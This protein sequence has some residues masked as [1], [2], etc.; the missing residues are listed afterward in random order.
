MSNALLRPSKLK[1]HR[2]K[3]HSQRK[4]DDIDALSSEE[5]DLEA[6]LPY[7]GFTVEEKRTPQCSCEVLYQI[8]KCKKPHIIAEKLIAEKMIE[9]AIGPGRLTAI[10]TQPNGV[11]DL[12][13][14]LRQLLIGA[15]FSFMMPRTLTAA[16][17]FS[18]SRAFPSSNFLP[19]L[20]LRSIPTLII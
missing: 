18:S 20:F 13:I 12:T 10:S 9:T 15:A 14:R 3:K 6:T 5:Y 16:S 1:N 19:P 11:G 8:A 7:S 4:N 2:D 17:L